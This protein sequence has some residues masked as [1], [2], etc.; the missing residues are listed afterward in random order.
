MAALNTLRTKGSILLTS[1]I[2][3][4]LLA[5]LLGDG[6]SLFSSNVTI[7]GNVDGKEISL[8]SYTAEV[9]SLTN[10]RQFMS[11]QSSLSTQETE[12]IQEQV[13]GKMVT[14]VAV[15]PVYKD[16]G[17]NVSDDELLDMV[18]GEYISPI[19]VQVF[20]DHQTGAFDKARLIEYV[21]NLDRDPSGMARTFWNYIEGSVSDMRI[22]EKYNAL[23]KQSMYVTS[24]QID[25]AVACNKDIYSI[26]YVTKSISTIS[27][28]QINVTDKDLED[29]YKKHIKRFAYQDA[30][31]VEYVT[32]DIVPSVKDFKDAEI[33]IANVLGE[34]RASEDVEQYVNY[35]SE[36]RFNPS[37]I[38]KNNLPRYLQEVI[39]N[40]KTG[41]TFEPNFENDIYTLSRLVDVVNIPDSIELRSVSVTISQNIDSI[42]NV[43]KSS[44]DG[45]NNVV[46]T[47]SVTG[48]V[49]S[50][51]PITINTSDLAPTYAEKLFKSK[52]GDVLTFDSNGVTQII[53]VV[54]TGKKIKKYKVGQVVISVVPSTATEQDIY[55]R[56]TSLIN[57]I[58]DKTTFEQAVANN[59]YIKRIAKVTSSQRDFAGLEDSRELVRWAFTSPV[60]AVSHVV[61]VGNMNVVA[62]HKKTMNKGN[63]PFSE[64]K[65]DIRP[66]YIA[67]AKTDM[68]IKE[69]SGASSL[70]ELASKQE[71]TV[72]NSEDVKF[73]LYNIPGIGIAPEVVGA[74]TS[75][76]EGVVSNGIPAGN[77]VVAIKM[78]SSSV[79]D[80]IDSANMKALLDSNGVLYIDNRVAEAISNMLTIKDSRVVYY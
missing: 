76:K 79:N 73:S 61:T 41:T 31:D 32:F 17:L 65:E 64:V 80:V 21:E 34:F 75:L 15:M 44:K 70:E 69:L 60:G 19:V 42:I 16:L 52:K 29:Y 22:T 25:Q 68:V 50:S 66:L 58:G 72:G 23:V 14:D 20:T 6:A 35:T 36:E 24:L 47:Q 30:V 3:I 37:Y 12:A 8:Q 5:F 56:A 71:T 53:S 43:I 48:E 57:E 40:A 26:E 10:I 13:W 62:F 63:A 33:N 4:S 18:S 2:G 78:T 59:Q 11:G 38:S 39:A 45:F 77:S 1:V 55:A 51:K 49:E 28:D 46:A 54:S 7:I 67:K 74:V 27:D 9:E